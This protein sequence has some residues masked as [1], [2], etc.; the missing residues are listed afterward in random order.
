MYIAIFSFMTANVGMVK[1]QNSP[2]IEF[3]AVSLFCGVIAVVDL[4]TYSPELL[5]L[6]LAN[7]SNY[8]TCRMKATRTS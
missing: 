4:K 8:Y 3:V 7:D 2:Q 1:R 5:C 6:K